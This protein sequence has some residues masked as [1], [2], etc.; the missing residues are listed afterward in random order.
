[1]QN[2]PTYDD[3][4]K[5]ILPKSV[6]AHDRNSDSAS[7]AKKKKIIGGVV[8]GAAVL[9]L[10]LGLTLRKKSDDDDGGGDGPGPTPFVPV[11]PYYLVGDLNDQT[12]VFTGVLQLD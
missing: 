10:V 8:L 4:T 7:S 3:G 2:D 11:N 5:P 12:Q 9:A 6:L 1:M